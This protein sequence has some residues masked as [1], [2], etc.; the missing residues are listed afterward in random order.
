MNEINLALSVVARSWITVG[1]IRSTG[2]SASLG[3]AEYVAGLVRDDLKAE[4]T[5]GSAHAVESSDWK[6]LPGGTLAVDGL[7]YGVSHPITLYGMREGGGNSR[8]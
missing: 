5:R 6:L 2:V 8:L 4:P 1:G 7:Q 3:I